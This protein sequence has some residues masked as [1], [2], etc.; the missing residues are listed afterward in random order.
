MNVNQTQIPNAISAKYIR[1]MDMHGARIWWDG[2]W[3]TGV[4]VQYN[5]RS[6]AR[7]ERYKWQ[8]WLTEGDNAEILD[9]FATWK[10]ACYAAKKKAEDVYIQLYAAIDERVGKVVTHLRH[11]RGAL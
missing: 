7:A 1:D 6:S 4:S 2:K 8:V 9:E 3:D 5:R 10:E 11:Q